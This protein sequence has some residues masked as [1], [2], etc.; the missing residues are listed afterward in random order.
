MVS[1]RP[2]MRRRPF[3]GMASP[4]PPSELAIMV[5]RLTD[6]F[7]VRLFATLRGTMFLEEFFKRRRFACE[8][9]PAP[10]GRW[11]TVRLVFPRLLHSNPG[12]HRWPVVRRPAALAAP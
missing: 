2:T 11:F 8:R 7:V 4:T 6:L 10:A 5:R 9:R 1:A 3:L 12:N